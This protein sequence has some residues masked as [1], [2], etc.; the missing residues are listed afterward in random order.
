M[1]KYK[2]AALLLHPDAIGWEDA[3]QAVESRTQAGS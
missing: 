3:D 2:E 1:A